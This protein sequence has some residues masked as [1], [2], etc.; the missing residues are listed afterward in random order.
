VKE[1]SSPESATAQNEEAPSKES[2][3]DE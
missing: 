1:P 3:K 2:D